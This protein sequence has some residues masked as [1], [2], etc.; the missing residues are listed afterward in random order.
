[1]FKRLFWL[2]VGMACGAALVVFAQR[3]AKRY[4]PDRVT[5]DLADAVRRFGADLRAA[6]EEGRVAM[7]EREA[8]IRAQIGEG[9]PPGRP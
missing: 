6:V 7:A 1:M 2:I 8:D 4:T 9:A 5:T 3:T